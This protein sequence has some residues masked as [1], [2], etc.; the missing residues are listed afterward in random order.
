[1]TR[2]LYI[3]AV[4]SI[5]ILSGC[6]N[7][8]RVADGKPLR[9]RDPN[10]IIK[11]S[12]KGELDWKWLGFKMNADL[13]SNGTS[14]N[15]TLNVRMAKD[16][17][18]WVS[19]TPALGVEAARVLLKPDSVHIICKVPLNKFYYSGDYSQ[20]QNFLG[21]PFDYYSFQE[22]LSGSPLGLDP[23]NDKFISKVDGAEYVLIEKFP[24]KVK[25]LLGGMDEKALAELHSD[26][27][28][29]L[30]NDRKADRVLGRTNTE[31]LL[32]KRYWLN[33]LTFAPTVDV[34]NDLKSGLTIRVERHGDEGHEEGLLP[35]K[36]LLNAF[37]ERV[38]LEAELEVRRSRVNKEYDLPFDP[39]SD[40]ERRSKL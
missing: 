28:S 18:I 32:I 8:K 33:G 34:F 5:I 15:F 22:L 1:M 21:V 30:M 39:P 13:K 19:V 26:S 31:D 3:L 7:A 16:S 4:F 20:L 12:A 25:R 10:N 40:Y 38:D 9:P 17:A 27:L 24:R 14:E 6:S 36:I 37:G 35:T 11:Q 2:T 23:N 29:I